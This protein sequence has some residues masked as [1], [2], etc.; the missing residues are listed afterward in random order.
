[1]ISQ[2]FLAMGKIFHLVLGSI[3]HSTIALPPTFVMSIIFTPVKFTT[4]VHWF[5][6]S[7]YLREKDLYKQT[8]LEISNSVL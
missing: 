7:I 4:T 8:Q 6:I 1:M 3:V 2:F 5:L